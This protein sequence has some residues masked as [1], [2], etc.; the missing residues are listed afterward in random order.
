MMRQ[1]ATSMVIALVL[2]IGSTGLAQANGDAAKY[3]QSYE[4]EARGNYDKAL[5]VLG[6]VS[7]D[8]RA[9]YTYK[10]RKGW[11]L[12]LGGEYSKAIESYEA[13]VRAEPKAVEPRVG[14]MLPQMAL[15]NWKDAVETGRKALD[16]DKDNYLAASR[17]AWSLYNLGRYDDAE[18]YYRRMIDLYPSD[19]EMKAGLAWSLLEQG[20]KSKAAALFEEVLD[21]APTHASSL[22]GVRKAR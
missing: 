13:A 7:K 11:L 16:I 22:E 3:S 12:Y 1:L 9:T 6:G 21:V 4:L 8:Q 19:V 5:S 18:R 14:L 15:R 10:L 17:L 20:Q 2:G